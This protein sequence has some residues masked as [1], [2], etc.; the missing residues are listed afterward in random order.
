MCSQSRMLSIGP[1]NL[2]APIGRGLLQARSER[3]EA[4]RTTTARSVGGR[5]GASFFRHLAFSSAAETPRPRGAPVVPAV[6]AT[7]KL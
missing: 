3:L 7:V 2:S 6:V 4:M 1:P 5:G